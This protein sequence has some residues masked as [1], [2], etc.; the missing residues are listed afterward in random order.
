M[1]QIPI[2]VEQTARGERAY[3]L[4]SR[5][6]KDRIIMLTGTVDDHL[7]SLVMAQLLFLES[8]DP[9]KEISVYINSPGGSMPAGLAIYDT[10]QHLN[11]PVC[12]ICA[13]TAASMGALLLTAGTPGRRCALPNSRAMIHQPL[14]PGGLGGQ[15]T[16]IAIYAREF[17][18]HKRTVHEILARHTGQSLERIREDTERDHWFSSEEARA[19]GLIDRVLPPRRPATTA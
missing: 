19:Y 6:L 2:V 12:T 9:D 18:L 8:E 3:D 16:D 7:A 15:V 17:E 10:M 4:Y 11:A 13:G 5:L 1:L 14:L